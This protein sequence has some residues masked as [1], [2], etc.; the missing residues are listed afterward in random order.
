MVE[1][2]QTPSLI[3]FAGNPVIF[4]AYSDNYQVSFGSYAYF[5]LLVYGIETN[6]SRTFTIRFAGKT[7]VFI[8]A[9][10]S[11]YDGLSI[12]AA[13]AGQ[14]C[15]D[16]AVNI[17]KTFTEN[18]DLQ[19]YFNISLVP[20][21]DY[22]RK[23]TLQAKQPGAKYSVVLSD[24][25]VSG[26][27]P[28]TNTPGTDRIYND[29]F[30]VLCLVRDAQGN[31]VG[32]DLKP[33]DFI[34]SAGFDI[35]DFLRAKFSSWELPRFEFPELS[36][37][38]RAHGWDYLLKYRTSFAESIAGNIK[39]LRSDTFR[40][41]LAGGL[42]HELLT[43]LNENLLE[44][45]SVAENKSRFLSWLP[46]TK[47]SRSGVMEKLF[48]LF[49]DYPCGSKYKLVVIV[50]FTDGSNKVID[51]SDLI[52][53][54]SFSVVEFKVGFDHLNLINARYGKTVK[55]W[56]VFL[57]D[58]NDEFISEQRTFFNDTGF[59]ENEK[60]FFY[61][62]SFS[63]YDTF[64]FLGKSELNFEYDRL[65]G[66]TI[67]EENYSFFN[68]PSIQFTAKETETCKANSGWVS[69]EEKNCLRELLLSTEAY[70]QIGLEL[71]PIVVKT[72]KVTPF[73]KGGE[74]LY[75]LELE[76]QRSYENSFFSVHKPLS[77]A[78]PVVVPHPLTWDTM[79]FTFDSAE[80]TFD[81][82]EY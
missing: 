28:G 40:Y 78:I 21:S 4:E 50:F 65:I 11:N 22:Q 63:A 64:R 71:F 26:I 73:F 15:I 62:N 57:F 6:F 10:N 39:G 17:H 32:E 72:A 79:N 58:E 75:N 45:F 41:A 20:V 53:I 24:V 81:Q 54:T 80:I 36:G 74:Y 2:T 67:I 76:Y 7:Y 9:V 68:A 52:D 38:C 31:P 14:T 8:T 12:R 33:T 61:R 18:Y 37:N 16:F 46:K 66:S 3:S 44:F 51:G 48:F 56:E 34:G 23:I 42:G 70:E 69:H 29:Y 55:A 30:S 13:Y 77:S 1:I 5:E 35:S 49:Q 60:V 25:Q 43:S 59:Y 19:K 82:I 27:G 47:R